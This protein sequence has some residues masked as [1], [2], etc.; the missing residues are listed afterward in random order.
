MDR[1]V[2]I[3]RMMFMTAAAGA[4]IVALATPLAHATSL[5]MRVSEET[6]YCLGCHGRPGALKRFSNGETV[7]VHVDPAKFRAS[8]HRIL[9]CTGC[10]EEF[11]ADMHPERTFRGLVQYRARASWICRKCH[12]NEELRTRGVHASL[13]DREQEGKAFVC[14]GCHG[15]HEVM[16]VS[17][18]K[19]YASEEKYCLS[20]HAYGMPLAFAD[21]AVRSAVV[22]PVLIGASAHANLSCSD[23]HFGF[24][25]ERHPQRRFRSE[26]E[27]VLASAEL[28]KRCHFDKYQKRMGSIHYELL[29]QGRLEAPSCTDC[30]GAH[31]TGYAGKDRVS[32][33]RKC[34]RFHK[35]I[36]VT[37]ANS[38]HGNALI[39]ESNLDVPTCVDCHLPHNIKDPTVSAYHERIP[40]MCSNCHAD[41]EIMAKYGLSTDVVSTYLSD[42]HGVTLGLY[43]KQKGD[44]PYK[45][46]RPIAVC[47]DC[48]GTHNITDTSG[49]ASTVLRSNLLQRCRMC[50]KDATADFPDTWLS[51]YGPTLENAPLVFIITWA[52]R[53]L[54]PLMLAGLL[55]QVFLHVW[56]FLVNR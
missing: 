38:V 47:T 5:D 22:D 23:C 6:K 56:R 2:A 18:G 45:P 42:F 24:S 35:E 27:F 34:H 17:G 9:S 14:A 48:H 31:Y 25:S 15:A 32:I 1:L 26:R 53:I 10:H 33:A 36:F 28:C 16:P 13:L 44:V 52:Y 41:R 20:C 29:S 8:V 30:H 4:I 11:S 54:M 55:L 50:H 3:I 21:G 37:Y 40:E 43:K 49:P 19:V 39:N 46:A 7:S 51:H 12:R